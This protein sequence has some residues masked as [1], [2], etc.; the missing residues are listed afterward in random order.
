MREIRIQGDNVIAVRGSSRPLTSKPAT[1]GF[2]P[3]G[4][5]IGQD[6]FSYTVHQSFTHEFTP[7]RSKSTGELTNGCDTCG[8]S[9]EIHSPPITHVV[10]DHCNVIAPID[11][12]VEVKCDE[13]YGR[14]KVKLGD[15]AVSISRNIRQNRFFCSE[16]CRDAWF[17]SF[18][19]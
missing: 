14:Q 8:W 3:V 19:G 11:S 17:G 18:N 6:G 2:P 4:S 16:W 12:L 7:Y 9:K 15:T 1:T 5:P 13:D 10:C